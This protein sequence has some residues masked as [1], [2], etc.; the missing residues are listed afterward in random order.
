M[1]ID[2]TYMHRCLQLAEEGWGSVAPNPMVGAVMVHDNIIIGEGL[3]KEYG[4]A[5]AEVN[6]V[7]SV[8]E[9]DQHLIASSTLYVS[10]EPCAHFGKTPPC[11]NLIIKHQIPKVVVGCRDSYEEVDGKGIAILKEAGV[12][13]IV[14]VLEKECLEMNARFFTFH[15]KRRPYIILKWAQS[16]DGHIAGEGKKQVAIS[17]EASKRLIHRWRTEEASIL[18]GT[19]TAL[20]D[21]PQLTARLWQG[22]DPVRLVM[23]SALRLPKDL[24]LFDQVAETVVFNTVKDEQE[25]KTR[26]YKLA[27][28]DIKNLVEACYDL[29]LQSVLVEGGSALLQSFIAE[30]LYDEIRVITNTAFTLPGGLAAPELKNVTL[31]K[32]EWLATDLI[33]YYS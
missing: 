26:F 15:Q 9:K 3:H 25:R 17:G 30:G 31:K 8:S 21:D 5:H 2:E 32:Q 7:N 29:K 28:M 6:C 20:I 11:T 13:V 14:G 24:K 1:T 12:K 4:Q 10:L 23:D 19:Q 18:V 33:Q 27:A 16:M 22:K